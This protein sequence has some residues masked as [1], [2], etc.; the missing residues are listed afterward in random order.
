MES[1]TIY[2]LNIDHLLRPIERIL[3]PYHD[4][5]HSVFI[6]G[7]RFP[8]TGYEKEHPKARSTPH[9]PFLSAIAFKDVLE[10]YFCE[11]SV[12][13]ELLYTNPLV[14]G[15]NTPLYG[16]SED[17]D[18]PDILYGLYPKLSDD[19]ANALVDAFNAILYHTL[20]KQLV[21]DGTCVYEVDI[22]S[23]EF[24]VYNKGPI[25]A[26]RF[27]ELNRTEASGDGY[28]PLMLTDF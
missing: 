12:F 26:L 18:I 16:V 27:D 25:K 20:P 24:I 28:I 14:E 6:P 11:N 19:D 21:F 2:I 10:L 15:L 3:T 5:T 13:K 23:C 8:V 7:K 9:H 17:M 22:E 4:F 1:S